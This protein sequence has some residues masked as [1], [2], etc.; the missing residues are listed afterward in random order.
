MKCSNFAKKGI[1]QESAFKYR[2]CHP[3]FESFFVQSYDY[4][5]STRNAIEQGGHVQG[6]KAGSDHY[7]LASFGGSLPSGMDCGHVGEFSIADAWPL[8][9]TRYRLQTATY[10]QPMQVSLSSGN[11]N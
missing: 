8:L 9:L 4:A 11:C 6:H 1:Y 3:S 7:Q 5:L 10:T 2:R